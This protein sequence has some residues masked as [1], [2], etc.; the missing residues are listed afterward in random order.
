MTIAESCNINGLASYAYD[1][2]LFEGGGG[3]GEGLFYV[4]RER[5]S[6]HV[7]NYRAAKNHGL[8]G[9]FT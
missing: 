3:G 9:S 5:G 6:F 7:N 1:N 2:A 8:G 4:P